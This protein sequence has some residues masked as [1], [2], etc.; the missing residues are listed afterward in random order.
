MRRTR[1]SNFAVHVLLLLIATHLLAV[2]AAGPAAYKVEML[3]FTNEYG[4]MAAGGEPARPLP[5]LQAAIDLTRPGAGDYFHALPDSE[6]ALATARSILENSGRYEVITDVAWRQPR[7]NEQSAKAVRIHGGLEYT[8]PSA[9][10]TQTG[11][12][13]SDLFNDRQVSSK[14]EQL[15]GTVKVE[16]GRYLDVTTDF[17]LREP[18]A[19]QA[20][21]M[22]QPGPANELY[23]FRIKHERRMQSNELYYL[24]HPLLGILVQITPMEERLNTQSSAGMSASEAKRSEASNAQA[25]KQLGVRGGG[26]N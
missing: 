2:S 13:N 18:V 12:L 1:F 3:V 5:N 19:T 24:D 11:I 16:P 26:G 22:N 6:L 9:A 20:L 21:G 23:Q 8:L 4:S 17:V 25:S 7:L 15:D 14:L 10:S